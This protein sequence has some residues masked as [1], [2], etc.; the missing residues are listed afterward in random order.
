MSDKELLISILGTEGVPQEAGLRVPVLR[1]QSELEVPPVVGRHVDPD[2][3]QLAGRIAPDRDPSAVLTSALP[4]S[5]HL[6]VPGVPALSA[7]AAILG[8]LPTEAPAVCLVVIVVGWGSESESPGRCP[9]WRIYQPC[10]TSNSFDETKQDNGHFGSKVFLT[11]NGEKVEKYLC[12]SLATLLSLLTRTCPT[13]Q[14]LFLG[15]SFLFVCFQIKVGWP[16]CEF[17]SEVN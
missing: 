14:D 6:E 12:T 11:I 10:V 16:Q 2:L 7:L 8:P 15:K 4:G 5:R 1:T 3:G 9:C 17:H 13:F